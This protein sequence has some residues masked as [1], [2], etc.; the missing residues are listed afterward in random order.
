MFKDYYKIL[1]V[2]EK[3]SLNEIKTAYRQLSKKYHPDMNPGI[4]TTAWMQDINEAYAILKDETKR[5][6]YDV[7]RLVH[8][9]V[10]VRRADEDGVGAPL[11]CDDE[12]SVRLVHAVETRGEIAAILRERHDVLREAR[13]ATGCGAGLHGLLT[14]LFDGLYCTKKRPTGQGRR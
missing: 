2:S 5:K 1:G 13:T 11:A 12:R 14:P 9:R 4:D 6:R 10:E 8:Q 3:A 7:E